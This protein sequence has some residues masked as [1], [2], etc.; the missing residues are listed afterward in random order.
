M[1]PFLFPVNFST[2][3]E[4]TSGIGCSHKWLVK[5]MHLP[6]KLPNRVEFPPA[7]TLRHPRIG[8]HN[9]ESPLLLHAGQPL[10]QKI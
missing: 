6:L 4:V 2:A 7:L 10:G 3:K 8:G 5:K 9:H 1:L